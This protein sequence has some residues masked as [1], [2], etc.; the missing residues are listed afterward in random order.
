MAKREKKAK[1][2]GAD[3]VTLKPR[4]ARAAKPAGAVKAHNTAAL[5][6]QRTEDQVREGWLHHREVWNQ[7]TARQKVLNKQWKDVKAALKADGYKV[8][9]MKI[10]DSLS[11]SEKQE[12]KVHGE[13]H[14]RLQVAYWMGHPMG[15]QFDLFTQPDRTPAVDRA[16]D[17]GKQASMENKACKP[18][19]DASTPQYERYMAGYQDHQGKLA[20][21][22]KPLSQRAAEPEDDPASPSGWG[23]SRERD[24]ARPL[25]A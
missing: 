4:K 24:P 22:F 2:D 25:D 13:V 7:M 16:Y 20:K 6:D 5:N 10:A 14:D 1:K 12:A 21:G 11:G 18:P 15:A 3:V 9:Q 23:E 19:Y 17:Q 8:G